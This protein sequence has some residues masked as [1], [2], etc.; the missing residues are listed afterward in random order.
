MPKILL[1]EDE[2]TLRDMYSLKLTKEGFEVVTAE[3]G[4]Q[5]LEKAKTEK[6]DMGFAGRDHPQDRW[7]YSP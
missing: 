1:V 2:Q 7:L 3:D 5:A 4:E 6:P